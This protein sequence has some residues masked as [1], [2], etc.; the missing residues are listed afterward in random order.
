MLLMYAT[1]AETVPYVFYVNVHE[2]VMDGSIRDVIVDGT[3]GCVGG[4]VGPVGVVLLNYYYTIFSSTKRNIIQQFNHI[5]IDA[6]ICCVTLI[7]LHKT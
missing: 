1:V 4:A 3:D 6:T 2:C 5:I 7:E